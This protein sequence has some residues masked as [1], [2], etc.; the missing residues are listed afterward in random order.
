MKNENEM[1][2]VIRIAQWVVLIY[3]IGFVV[4]EFMEW[5]L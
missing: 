1:P 5:F 4:H 3:G 2:L